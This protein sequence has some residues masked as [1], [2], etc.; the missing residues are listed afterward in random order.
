MVVEKENM[1]A[2]RGIDKLF[3]KQAVHYL[4]YIRHI[5]CCLCTHKKKW[6]GEQAS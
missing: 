1:Y 6:K 3:L 4:L 5:K 2:V